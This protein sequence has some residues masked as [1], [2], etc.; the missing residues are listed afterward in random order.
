MSLRKK[1]HDLARP[2]KKE[3]EKELEKTRKEADQERLAKEREKNKRKTRGRTFLIQHCIDKFQYQTYLEIGFGHGKNFIPIRIAD[4]TCVD[5]SPWAGLQNRHI[6]TMSSD[7]YFKSHDKKFDIIFID[8]DHRAKQVYKDVLNSITALNENGIIVVHDCFPPD[9]RKENAVNCGDGWRAL[10]FLRKNMDLDI[11]TMNTDLGLG[12]IK[13]RKNQT[14]LNPH[15]GPGQ[16]V[17]FLSNDEPEFKLLYYGILEF[18]NYR[19]LNLLS[20]EEGLKW[21]DGK[22]EK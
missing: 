16:L 2:A 3:L 21:I 19:V 7:E 18:D 9:E 8:G 5:P 22:N 6:V 17:K 13:K 12:M 4:K 10:C 20:I 14:W 11:A 1:A 15:E